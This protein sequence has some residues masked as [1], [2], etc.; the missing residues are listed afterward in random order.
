MESNWKWGWLLW[1][2]WPEKIQENRVAAFKAG[3]ENE[4]S[5]K[6]RYGK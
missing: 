4:K 3:T 6:K 2:G 5:V 1:L